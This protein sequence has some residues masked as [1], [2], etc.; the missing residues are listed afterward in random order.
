MTALIPIRPPQALSLLDAA[1]HDFL[2]IDLANGDASED[3][4]R[5]YRSTVGQW[6]AWCHEKR[7]DPATATVANIKHYRQ[8]LIEAGYSPAT[9]RWKLV[10]VRR[11]YEAARNAG[12][13]IDNPAAGVKSPR[14]RQAIEDFKYLSDSEL[15]R[16]LAVLPDPE[17]ATG[18]EKVRELRD[19]LMID[20][21]ALHG[22]RT[23]E[24]QRANVE[25]LTDKGEHFALVVRGKTRDRLVYLRPDTRAR[26][27]EY[28]ALGGETARDRDGTPLFSAID[29]PRHRLTRTRI[30]AIVVRYLRKA[31]LKR[32]GLSN[33]ALR[34]TAATLGYL[35]TGDL[36]AVQELLGHAN[37]RM[38]A[39]YA[40]VVDMAKKNP[41]LFIPVTV[42]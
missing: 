33:H 35:H 9:I 3:T 24:V 42:G 6:A 40:H 41:V 19:L 27:Q 23:I 34:H 15:T 17:R 5:N 30:R 11:F 22:L 16:F 10:I 2:R 25:D 20:M 4:I 12:L 14:I 21:M 31:G 37:P 38:T 13:R 36:R 18:P 28:V 8:A 1:F 7:I 39:R 26:M 32:P 29:S